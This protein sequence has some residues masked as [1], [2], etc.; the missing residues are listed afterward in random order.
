MVPGGI[1]VMMGNNNINV[2]NM[3]TTGG[4]QSNNYIQINTEN[5]A[6]AI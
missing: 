4:V 1:G 6:A 5:R 3:R 2:P